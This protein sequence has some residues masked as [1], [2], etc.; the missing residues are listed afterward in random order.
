MKTKRLG[1]KLKLKKYSFYKEDTLLY[2]LIMYI[3]SL[4]FTNGVFLTEFESPK[5]IYRLVLYNFNCLA[6]LW[7]PEWC[8]RF[9]FRD[10]LG[11]RDNTTVALDKAF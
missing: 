8:E 2:N 7:K 11:R 4:A 3:Q 1:G 9:V 10:I 5:D 6:F